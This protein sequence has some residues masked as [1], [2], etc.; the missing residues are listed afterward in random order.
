MSGRS[1]NAIKSNC[2][3]GLK[4]VENHSSR[5]I[6]T[7][8]GNNFSLFLVLRRHKLATTQDTALTVIEQIILV[9]SLYHEQD[10]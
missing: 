7:E 9:Q 4:K 10:N 8:E 2:G 6:W 1:A 5:V 3:R